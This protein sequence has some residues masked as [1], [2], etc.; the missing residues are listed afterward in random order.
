MILFNSW[1]LPVP[2]GDLILRLLIDGARRGGHKKNKKIKLWSETLYTSKSFL[3]YLPSF[4]NGIN[5]FC[6]PNSINSS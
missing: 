2:Y 3:V 1:V 4:L 6:F 5:L